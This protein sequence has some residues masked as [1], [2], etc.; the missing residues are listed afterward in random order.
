LKKTVLDGIVRRVSQTL[1]WGKGG[2]LGT[3]GTKGKGE[4]T[5]LI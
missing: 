4:L 1:G 5:I 2:F 3:R